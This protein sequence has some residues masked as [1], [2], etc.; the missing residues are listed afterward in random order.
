[1][2]EWIVGIIVVIALYFLWR[3]IDQYR[4]RFSKQ[5]DACNGCNSSCEGC[6]V[7]PANR[8]KK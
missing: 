6:P 3:R 8:K 7:V 4:R 1:M 2:Q 5:S